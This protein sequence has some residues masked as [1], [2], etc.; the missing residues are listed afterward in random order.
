MASPSF[1]NKL[2]SLVDAMN[3]NGPAPQQL[4]IVFALG[5]VLNEG[6]SLPRGTTLGM[7]TADGVLVKCV[8]TATDGSEIPYGI[9]RDSIEWDTTGVA[10]GSLT[11]CS[12]QVRGNPEQSQFM[13]FSDISWGATPTERKAALEPYFRAIGLST[14]RLQFS[15]DPDGARGRDGWVN[16][17]IVASRFNTLNSVDIVVSIAGDVIAMH[18]ADANYFASLGLVSILP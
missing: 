4:P 14:Y 8:K 3:I 16:V 18:E 2:Y 17:T 13:T 7:R 6:F 12:V 5:K 11:N 10:L 15:A 9:L 1:P